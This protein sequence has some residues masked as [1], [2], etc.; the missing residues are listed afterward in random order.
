MAPKQKSSFK[1]FLIEL[2][3]VFL[4]V[5]LAFALNQWNEGRKNQRTQEKLL[6]EL[7][8]GLSMDLSDVRM[9]VMGHKIGIR[10]AEIMKKACLENPLNQDSLLF[11]YKSLWRNFISIQN[12][13]AYE[14]LKSKGLEIINNDS[15]RNEIIA[16]YDFHFEILEKIEENYAEVQFYGNYFPKMQEQIAPYM[17]FDE[18]GNI[19]GFIQPWQLKETQLKFMLEQLNRIAFNRQYL[20]N[21]YMEVDRRIERLIKKLDKEIAK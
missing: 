10:S 5:T 8:N 3:S 6:L 21:Q 12:R 1:K 9:N 20:I 14:S 15:L 11:A 16:L 18:T 4:G 19:Q 17:I 2:V 13:S 7:R